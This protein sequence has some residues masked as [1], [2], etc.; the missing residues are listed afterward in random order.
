MGTDEAGSMTGPPAIHREKG[1]RPVVTVCSRQA[2]T[3]HTRRASAFA[4]RRDQA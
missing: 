2:Q 1:I 4:A 3:V